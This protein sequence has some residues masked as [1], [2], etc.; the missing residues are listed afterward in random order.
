MSALRI[1]MVRLPYNFMESVSCCLILF[2]TFLFSALAFANESPFVW[3]VEKEGKVSYILGTIHAGVSLEEIPCYDKIS[4]KIKASDLLF[5]ESVTKKGD[6]ESLSEEEQKKL[7][8]GSVKK[9]AEIMFKLSLETQETV[10][11]R[12]AVMFNLLKDQLTYRYVSVNNEEDFTQFSL[13]SQNF[14]TNLVSNTEMDSANFIY[15]LSAISYYRALFSLPSLDRQIKE[16]AQS[17]SVKMESL[18]N[19]LLIS[20]SFRSRET[21]DKP[22][23]FVSHNQVEEVIQEMDSMTEMYQQLILNAVQIYK[24]YDVDLF[25]NVVQN[26]MIDERVLLKE[27]NELWLKKFLIAHGEYEN[28]FISAG[29]KHFISSDNML[30]ML[31]KEGFSVERMTCF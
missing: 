22:I 18:D 1:K 26:K 15:Y 31:K 2:V 25:E 20:Q 11:L 4:S 9:Q 21:P 7:Y 28:I 19:S 14:L 6:L 24:T 29:L 16:I 13:E 27:R 23:Q 8:I 12:K 30:G 17:H 10:R 5:L 3:K